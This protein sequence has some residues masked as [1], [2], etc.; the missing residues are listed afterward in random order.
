M[1]LVKDIEFAHNSINYNNINKYKIELKEDI[2]LVK[3]RY[4]E[5]I[6]DEYKEFPGAGLTAL[7]TVNDIIKN[8]LKLLEK[9]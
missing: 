4:D 9:E 1:G 7:K 5:Y 6:T 2:K 3:E 8:I